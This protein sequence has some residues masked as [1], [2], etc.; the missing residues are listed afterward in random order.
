MNGRKW[1]FG[2]GQTLR[3]EHAEIREAQQA[4][5]AE[6]YALAQ[7]WVRMRQAELERRQARKRERRAVAA[8]ARARTARVKRSG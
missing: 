8:A 3:E 6:Q 1:R 4:G 7:R 5:L 2:D